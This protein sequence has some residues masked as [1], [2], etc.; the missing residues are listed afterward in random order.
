MSFPPSAPVTSSLIIGSLLLTIPG[1]FRAQTAGNKS[2]TSQQ[3]SGTAKQKPDY[4][5]ES[6]VVEQLSNAY[7]FESDGTG[8]VN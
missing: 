7:R 4:S 8:N 6:V 3:S 5:Q 1:S 2:Q